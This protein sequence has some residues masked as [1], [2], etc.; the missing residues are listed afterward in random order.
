[1]LHPVESRPTT[2]LIVH[3]GIRWA[4]MDE[5]RSCLTGLDVLAADIRGAEVNFLPTRGLP[6]H[7]YSDV[8][9]QLH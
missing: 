3:C 8:A 7:R 2:L 6:K 9:I 1:M 4:V 5:R